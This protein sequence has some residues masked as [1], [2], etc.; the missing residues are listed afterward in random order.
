[1]K[2]LSSE[3]FARAAHQIFDLEIG[4]ASLPLTL[5]D[6]QVAVTSMTADLARAPFSL[7]FRSASQ[8]V[9]PQKTY[10][11]RNAGMGALQIFLVPVGRDRE[12]V[13]Y[14]AVFN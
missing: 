10:V 1:M 9:L 6:V 3:D 4:E 13:L 12:G 8:V 5:I 2:V 14:Q 11:L 7:T